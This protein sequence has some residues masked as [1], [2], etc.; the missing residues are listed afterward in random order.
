MSSD[1]IKNSYLMANCVRHFISQIVYDP[2]LIKNPEITDFLGIKE[3]VNKNKM[4]KE[5]L[6]PSTDW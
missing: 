2:V 5:V 3:F 1:A 6:L 4:S